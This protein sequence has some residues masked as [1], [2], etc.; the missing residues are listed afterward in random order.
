V[1][2]HAVNDK[3]TDAIA[4]RFLAVSL[5]SAQSNGG[6][7]DDSEHDAF[8]SESDT[9]DR[10]DSS[11]DDTLIVLTLTDGENT[12]LRIAIHSPGIEILA[13]NVSKYARAAAMRVRRPF[14]ATADKSGRPGKQ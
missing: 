5:R 9:L 14:S 3:E 10:Q 7:N 12:R 11:P 4:P 13:R 6:E 1:V 8:L 2:V